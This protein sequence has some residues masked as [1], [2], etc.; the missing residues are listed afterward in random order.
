MRLRE[1]GSREV[2]AGG[3]CGCAARSRDGRGRAGRCRAGRNLVVLAAEMISLSCSVQCW[4]H[5]THR[6][7]LLKM[8]LRLRALR[9]RAAR[10]A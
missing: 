6:D 9:Q 7:E 5:K 4:R 1:S 10:R 8:L 2:R 3:R